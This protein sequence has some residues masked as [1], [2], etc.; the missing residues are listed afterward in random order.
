MP[1]SPSVANRS[2]TGIKGLLRRGSSRSSA[3]PARFTRTD[4]EVPNPP[5]QSAP[6]LELTE[7][8]TASKPE[9]LYGKELWVVILRWLQ[10]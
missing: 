10:A 9:P 5:S 1:T 8:S 3:R 7:S 2:S 6:N 4:D